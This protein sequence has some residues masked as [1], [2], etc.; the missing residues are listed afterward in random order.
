MRNG[1]D[2]GQNEGVG[3]R[4]RGWGQNEGV[5]GRMRGWGAQWGVGGGGLMVNC[6][7]AVNGEMRN[8][9]IILLFV[10]T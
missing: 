6:I 3:G 9:A 4:M 8:L 10:N 2:G 1:G 5:G 7:K